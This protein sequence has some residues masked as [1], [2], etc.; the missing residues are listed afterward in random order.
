MT[1]VALAFASEKQVWN[2][3]FFAEYVRESGF[4]PYIGRKPNSIIVAKG[5]E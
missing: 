5:K 4:K 2:K 1:E 3:D